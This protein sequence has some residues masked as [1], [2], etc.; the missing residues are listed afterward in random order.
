MSA[1]PSVFRVGAFQDSVAEPLETATTAIENGLS[2]AVAD[3]SLTR[4]MMSEYVP[5]CALVGAPES[6]PVEALN[7]AHAGTLVAEKVS[8]LPSASDAVG[9]KL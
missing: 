9:R 1:E 2:D 6:C 3:P 4:I 8:V 7:T 5:R